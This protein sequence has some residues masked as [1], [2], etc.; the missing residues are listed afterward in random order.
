MSTHAHVGSGMRYGRCR[1]GALMRSHTNA[2]NS[3]SS[4]RQYTCG[5]D[6]RSWRCTHVTCGAGRCGVRKVSRCPARICR[7]TY[8]LPPFRMRLRREIADARTF[9]VSIS[10]HNTQLCC[11]SGT[12]NSVRAG[13]IP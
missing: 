1:C 7:P 2:A 5:T 9:L 12:V 6:G 10:M 13:A 8:L 3:S 11:A 4:A